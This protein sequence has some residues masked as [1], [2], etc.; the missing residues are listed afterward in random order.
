MKYTEDDV[1]EQLVNW[2]RNEADLD[3][4]AA[5]YSEHTADK[6]D[7]VVIV[8]RGPK[9]PESFPYVNG[10]SVDRTIAAA[11]ELLAALKDTVSRLEMIS[12]DM[13]GGLFG[14]GFGIEEYEGGVR[15]CHRRAAEI[16]AKAEGRGE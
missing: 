16:I 9:G 1:T 15:R 4:L 7:P 2:V 6:D 8:V 11:P 3:D 14:H 13:R 5:M 12:S 10:A